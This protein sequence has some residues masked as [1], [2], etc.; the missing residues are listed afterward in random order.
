METKFIP[1]QYKRG[2]VSIVNISNIVQVSKIDRHSRCDYYLHLLNAFD[3]TS[4]NEITKESY[5]LLC[6]ELL[7]KKDNEKNV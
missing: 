1:I 4:G 3:E 7:E 5:D 2:L 6:Q